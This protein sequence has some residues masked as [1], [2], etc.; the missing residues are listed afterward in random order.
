[1]SSTGDYSRNGSSVPFARLM[2][3]VARELLGDPNAALSD[4]AELR[5]GTR[6]ALSINR[7]NGTWCDHADG[8]RGGGLLDLLKAQKGLDKDDALQWLRD[9]K[10]LPPAEDNRPRVVSSY[11]YVDAA[12]GMLFQVCRFEPKDF[13]QRRPDGRG[14]WIWKTKGLSLVLFRLPEVIA[15][16]ATG[17]TIYITEGEKGVSALESIGLVGT[18]S[19][20]GAGKWR[21]EYSGWLRGADVVLLPDNDEAGRKHVDQVASALRGV[22]RRVRVLPLP[23]AEGR[24]RRLGHRRRHGR[25]AGKARRGSSASG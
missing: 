19:P 17:R 4:D 25:G 1:M 22:A 8:D 9:R 10:H 20:A 6:G 24:H 11:D 18:C 16:V 13:R 12:G 5:W 2:E 14:G 3:P 7:M 21:P 15:A 23:G